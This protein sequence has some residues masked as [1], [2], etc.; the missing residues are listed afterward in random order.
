MT[1]QSTQQRTRRDHIRANGS[2]QSVISSNDILD[3][4]LARV[5]RL[6]MVLAATG[7]ALHDVNN[8]LTVLSGHLYLMTESVRDQPDLYSK[9]RNARNAAERA[10]TLIHEL[11]TFA[12]DPHEDAT[13]ICPARHVVAMKSLLRRS[14][15]SKHRFEIRH[16]DSPWSVATSAAQLESA[17]ANLVINAHEAMSQPGSIEVCIENVELPQD[18]ATKLKLAPGEYVCLQVIDTGAGIPADVLSRVTEPLFTSK[19]AGQGSGMGLAMVQRFT[20]KALG[21]LRVNSVEG[22]G[23]RV[24][25]WLPRTDRSSEVTASMT[26]PLSTL[27]SGEESVLLVAHDLDVRDTVHQLLEALGYRVTST[28]MRTEAVEIVRQQMDVAIFICDRSAN[29]VEQDWI[30]AVRRVKPEIRHLAILPPGISAAD[31]APD[32]NAYLYQPIGVAELA[33]SM[34]SALEPNPCR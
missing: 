23:T 16:S 2:D 3:N 10:S 21:G 29:D 18:R 28:G 26:I 19:P 5:G 11:L 30:D 15:D 24:Q 12:R 6:E 9:S 13:V 20:A 34:R 8:L 27:P 31:A 25:I 33:R 17:L 14:I 32:A 1:Q 4:A 22:C 7:G